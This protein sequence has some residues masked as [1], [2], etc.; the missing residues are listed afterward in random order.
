M[1]VLLQWNLK[2]DKI[3]LVACE[4]AVPEVE[5]RNNGQTSTR[6]KLGPMLTR[7][8]NGHVSITTGPWRNGK[9]WPGQMNVFFYI[10]QMAGSVCA[11]YLGKR[12]HKDAAWGKKRQS[13]RGSAML[14]AMFCWEVLTDVTLTRTT[15]LNIV[16]DQVHPFM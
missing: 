5:S 8:Y 9:R 14:W 3:Y 7:I 10:T 6:D 1:I 4:H 2:A 15:Y 16:A 12:Q 11:T 13:G